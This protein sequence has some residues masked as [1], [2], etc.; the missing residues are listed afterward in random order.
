ML[1]NNGVMDYD[2]SA[3]VFRS[4]YLFPHANTL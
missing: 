3:E 4:Q 1:K 2:S